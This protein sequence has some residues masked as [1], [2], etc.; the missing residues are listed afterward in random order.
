MTNVPKLVLPKTIVEV[1]DKSKVFFLAGPIRGGGD[2]Q[3]QA[4]LRIAELMPEAFIATPS[5][6]NE[7]HPLYKY[8]LPEDTQSL[9][10]TQ[11]AWVKKHQTNWERYYLEI[12]SRMGCIL[13]WLPEEDINNP[14]LKEDGP[15]A[16]DTYGELGEWRGRLSQDQSVRLVIGAME[17]FLGLRAI[18][19]NY[20]AVDQGFKYYTCLE[21]T[22]QAAI[23]RSK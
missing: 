11:V 20:K 10:D 6:Y 15:Y 5:R 3:H 12:A 16:Q 4:I 21:D 9:D 2:W 7:N 22:I 17:A 8:K 18:H 1:P 13:F 14:R 23:V 19:R